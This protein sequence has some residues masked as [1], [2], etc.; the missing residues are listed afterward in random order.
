MEYFVSYSQKAYH[1]W[2]IELLIQS[3][4]NHNLQDKLTVAGAN[5]G[6]N[7]YKFLANILNHENFFNHLSIGLKRG[8]QQLDEIY[9]LAFYQESKKLGSEI[10]V[11]QPHTVLKNPKYLEELRT[12]Q[13]SATVSVDPF[14]TFDYAEKNA[15]DFWVKQ[16]HSRE[17]YKNNWLPVGSIIL[18]NNLSEKISTRAI[19]V[20]EQIIL[21]QIQQKIPVWSESIK[22]AW[23][24]SIADYLGLIKIEASYNLV[25]NMIDGAN[26]PFIDYKDGVLPVFNKSMFSFAPPFGMSFGDPIEVL[27]TCKM[28]PN[29]DYLSQISETLLKLRT[30]SEQTP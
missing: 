6:E 22:L 17:F 29:A 7:R 25:S 13:S 15:G 28:S 8:F 4:K 19:I 1:D 3:F 5:T 12:N 24:I 2:Q 10:C 14:F 16:A 23:A 27:A 9:S 18:F 11:M 26:A 20:A 21:N 30:K